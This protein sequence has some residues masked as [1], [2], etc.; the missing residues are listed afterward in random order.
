MLI[1]AA[2]A[3][4]SYLSEES[5]TGERPRANRSDGPFD[6]F[7]DQESPAL[8]IILGLALLGSGGYGLL[9]LSNYTGIDWMLYGALVGGGAYVFKRTFAAPK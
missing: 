7:F 6:R 3:V 9:V 4:I 5:A 1:G 2:I 8:P